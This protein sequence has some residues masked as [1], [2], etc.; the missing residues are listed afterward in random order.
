MTSPYTT[1]KSVAFHRDRKRL[2]STYGLT[3][4]N[5]SWS[6]TCVELEKTSLPT[7]MRIVTPSLVGTSRTSCVEPSDSRIAA[8][9]NIGLGPP[10]PGSSAV[11]GGWSS[12]LDKKKIVAAPG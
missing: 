7:V 4:C 2:G 3:T 1:S 5:V 11:F 8:V 6:L 12:T 10:N 9:E